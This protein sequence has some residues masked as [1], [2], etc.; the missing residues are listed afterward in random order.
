MSFALHPAGGASAVR[1][2]ERRPVGRRVRRLGLAVFFVSIAVN[3][4]LGIYALLTPDWSDTQGK[5]LGTSLCVT[6][7]ILVALACEP[8]WECG[9]LGFVPSA[10]ALLGLAGFSLTVAA[11]WTEP[12]SDSYGRVTGTLLTAAVACVLAS[13]LALA[14]LAPSHRWLFAVTL[15]LLTIAAAMFAGSLW[16]GDD[17]SETYMRA[18]GVAVIALAAFAVTVPVLH[19]V[20]RGALAAAEAVEGTVRYCPH[21]GSGVAGAIDA[22]LTC[23]RCGREFSV[24][25]IRR[26]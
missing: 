20:D 23:G 2:T 13:L 22:A 25:T 5:I 7:A 19:W 11:I 15:G 4:A 17:P 9:L 1:P 14:R 18:L 10:G 16:Q 12:A 26:T 6:G 3:A 8:A 24:S 21:C